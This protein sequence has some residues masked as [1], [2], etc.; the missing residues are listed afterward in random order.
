MKYP[1]IESN[2]NLQQKEALQLQKMENICQNRCFFKQFADFRFFGTSYIAILLT[3]SFK[4]NI[5][6]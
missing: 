1:K 6:A 2:I 5:L 3:E 4:L